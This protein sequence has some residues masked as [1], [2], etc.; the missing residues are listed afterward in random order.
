MY[1]DLDFFFFFNITLYKEEKNPTTA[2]D[3]KPELLDE[4]LSQP[5]T[6]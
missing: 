3:R 4:L 6:Y 2:T 1:S 5:N